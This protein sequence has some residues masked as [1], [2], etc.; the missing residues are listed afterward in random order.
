MDSRLEQFFTMKTRLT[1][2]YE[3]DSEFDPAQATVNET[4]LSIRALKA[5]KQ[6]RILFDY[7]ELPHEVRITLR[8]VERCG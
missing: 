4:S 2:V 3:G 1:Y 5:A 7:T 8:I 6:E